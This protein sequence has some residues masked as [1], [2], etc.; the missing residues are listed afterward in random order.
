MN[1]TKNLIKL[2]TSVAILLIS[3]TACNT[4]SVNESYL[5]NSV[6]SLST[7]KS[8][9]VNLGFFIS[10]DDYNGN[11]LGGIEFNHSLLSLVDGKDNLNIYL[12]ADSDVKNDGFRTK[13][14]T[15]Q[16]WQQNFIPV[17]ELNTGRTPALRDYL[18][19]INKQ[20]PAEVTH[21]VL[22]SHGGASQ[23]IMWDYDGNIHGPSENLSLQ[24]VFKSLSKGFTGNRIDSLNFDAC[25][26]ASIEVGESIKG[27]AKSYSGSEDF[28][29]GASFPWSRIFNNLVQNN[30]ISDG[31]EVLKESVNDVINH[32]NYGDKGSQTWSAI[33]L[34][35]N[36]DVLVSK[37]D[38]LSEYL[39]KR[40]KVAPNEIKTAAK[41]TQMFSI[42]QKYAVHYGDF[43]Q[44]D[45]IEFCELLKQNSKDT[46]LNQSTD[47]VIN[48]VKSVLIAE[49]HGKEET[50]AHGL[51]IY[52]P[53][54]DK[55]SNY[56]IAQLNKYRKTAFGSH[57]KWDEF[58]MAL[59]GIK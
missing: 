43:Y 50:M 54:S 26:M 18:Q 39:I 1:F 25:M 56:Q 8:G 34:D 58:L 53:I 11:T 7:K 12:S 51:A 32:G 42:M 33:R 16:K 46:I 31:E 37:V 48:A 9:K 35:H 10:M 15:G 29:M 6:N 30:K 59:N 4:P 3:I 52:L 55:L 28:G 40:L 45:L 57:T 41:Q 20:S 13:V 19:W 38:K 27:I 49:A 21:L 14:T 24:Q 23:G 17:G 22:G 36:F 2:A 44:R 5:D 47:D